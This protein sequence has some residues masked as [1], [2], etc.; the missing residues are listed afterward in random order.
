MED[1]VYNCV[2]TALAAGFEKAKTLYSEKLPIQFNTT[3]KVVYNLLCYMHFRSVVRHYKIMKSV[4]GRNPL[5]LKQFLI[6]ILTFPFKLIANTWRKK[7]VSS[8]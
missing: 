4:Y 8:F 5:F 1:K 7:I 3:R 6:G 2:K